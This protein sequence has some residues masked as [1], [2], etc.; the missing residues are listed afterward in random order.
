MSGIATVYGRG[1]RP[2]QHD[3]EN[4]FDAL[5]HRN[6]DGA[7]AVTHDRVA[8]GHQHAY[9]TPEEVGERQPVELD[10][11]WI[12]FD[13]RV[14]NRTEMLERLSAAEETAGSELSDA[15]L[16]LRAYRAFGTEF[17]EHLV[18][19]FAL[20]I[21]DPADE[22]L[23]LARDK[24][25]IRKLYYADTGNVVVV[26]SEM[27]AILEHPSVSTKINE[28]FVGEL[29]ADDF[30]TQGETFYADV[31]IVQEGS[32]VEVTMDE[33]RAESYWEVGNADVDVDPSRE[34]HEEFLARLEQAVVSRLRA[35][36]L[37]GIMMSGGLDSTTVTCVARRYLDRTGVDEDLHSFSLTIDDVDYF[38]DEID[39][40]NAVVEACDLQ[41]H[42]SSANEHF[43]L[44]DVEL[45]ERAAGETPFF[46]PTLQP[47]K[48][49]YEQA[50]A[51]GRSVLLTGFAGNV[52]D[53]NR[54]AYLDM[55]REGRLGTFVRQALSDSLSF[56]ELLLWF[57]LVPGSDRLGEFVMNRYDESDSNV[58]SWLSAE[59]VQ[60][61]GLADRLD[62]SVRT[63]IDSVSKE[64]QF[65]RYFRKLRP[66]EDAIQHRI[67]LEAGVELRCPYLDSRL[68]EYAM[69]LPSGVLFEAG[70][71][72]ALVRRALEGILPEPVRTQ[73]A[74][75]HFD[76][77]VD[78]GLLDRREAYVE[79]LFEE[80][81]LVERG[82]VDE[83]AYRSQVQHL[84]GDGVGRRR[85]WTLVTLELWL[86][87]LS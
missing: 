2:S 44:K 30:V 76:P 47:N 38:E 20:A 49:V 60:R 40:M 4:V 75:V 62:E 22:R 52:Y 69:S 50:S 17:L 32:F 1:G 72:K 34:V 64:V 27:Q 14:D 51:T 65:K 78:I 42:V 61:S 59:F 83:S 41:S 48:E 8:L 13:G 63:D 7:D 9:T 86:R 10:D 81:R 6:W 58:P 85:I 31:R 56:R 79:E 55:V 87:Q 43:T 70:Q 53:G 82:F 16:T 26:A 46:S 74:A 25:G 12:T 21:W 29:L 77:V 24:T 19:A 23:V 36:K 5:S 54:L 15:E 68:L 73:S 33:T 28:G 11:L 45:Y 37:P 3:F 18:G 66:F 84:L 80:S 71:D 67:A 57:V 35:P 39:R